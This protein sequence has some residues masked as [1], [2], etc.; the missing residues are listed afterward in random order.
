MHYFFVE[1]LFLF[2]F[3]LILVQGC[4]QKVTIEALVP[5]EIERV[6][7]TKKVAVVNFKND[8]IGVSRKIE[9]TLAKVKINHKNYFTLISR[10]D[11]NKIIE[12]QKLQSSALSTKNSSVKFGELVSAEA[13]ISG[14]VHY[15]GNEDSYYYARRVRCLDEKC[16]KLRRYTVRC[17]KRVISLN[18]D[19]RIVDVTKGDIIF[20]DTFSRERAYRHCNDDANALPSGR[21]VAQHFA[22]SI[23]D[24]FVYKLTPHYRTFEVELLDEPDLDYSDKEEDLLKYALEYI[25]KKRYNKAEELLIRLIDMT[26]SKSYV[27]FYDLGVIYEARGK[28]KQAKEY[29]EYAQ[30]LMLAPVDEI[31]EAV[32]RIDRLIRQ[33]QKSMEQLSR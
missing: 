3:F 25:E 32:E 22:K 17:I 6:S 20:A 18:V 11:F 13:I 16:Q 21:M 30:N 29:Y 7:H 19:I 10:R 33:K 15:P 28:Y 9:A 5:A 8:S 27:P 2:F 12:E 31:D 23:A 4:S 1:K 24:E 26:D 14:D